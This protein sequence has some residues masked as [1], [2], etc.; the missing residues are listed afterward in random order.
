MLPGCRLEPWAP[1]RRL[2]SRGKV[3]SQ[4]RMVLRASNLGGM[5]NPYLVLC[6]CPGADSLLDSRP[7]FCLLRRQLQHRLDNTNSRHRSKMLNSVWLAQGCAARA[8]A[9]LLLA[10]NLLLRTA[11]LLR[12]G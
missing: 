11:R 4:Q 1:Q 12:E 7:I 6:L 8:A 5:A 2:C 9:K 10:G 3:L